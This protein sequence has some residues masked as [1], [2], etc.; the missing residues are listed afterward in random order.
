M[1]PESV[2][3]TPAKGNGT[4]SGLTSWPLLGN[5]IFEIHR[6]ISSGEKLHYW[7][8]CVSMFTW[9]KPAQHPKKLIRWLMYSSFSWTGPW[10][11][12]GRSDF[13]FIYTKQKHCCP[14]ILNDISWDVNSNYSWGG[15]GLVKSDQLKERCRSMKALEPQ[16]H[17]P[18]PQIYWRASQELGFFF[19]QKIHSSLSY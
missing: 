8:D 2:N 14:V 11:K 16:G 9:K 13:W 1:W 3:I 18:I 12:F 15:R 7:S 19:H 17:K 6:N 5:L 4:A 10:R